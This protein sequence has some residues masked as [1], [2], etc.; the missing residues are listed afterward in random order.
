MPRPSLPA[1]RRLGAAVAATAGIALVGTSVSGIAQLDGTLAA[2]DAK[3]ERTTPAPYE[4]VS[5]ERRSAA[6]CA[7]RPRARDRRP[8]IAY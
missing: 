8:P 6:D 3:A 1:L 2:A 5:F 4:R 7:D